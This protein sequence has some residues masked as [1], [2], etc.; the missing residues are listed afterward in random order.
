M[1][2]GLLATV[3]LLAV[4]TQVAVA[5]PIIPRRSIVAEQLNKAVEFIGKG[6]LRSA[7]IALQQI[8]RDDPSLVEVRWAARKSPCPQAGSTTPHGS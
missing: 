8:L 4:A 5:E 1:R 7:D 2:R 6:D 3:A